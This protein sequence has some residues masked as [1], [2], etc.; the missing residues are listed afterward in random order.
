MTPAPRFWSLQAEAWRQ[1][2]RNLRDVWDGRSRVGFWVT[3]GAAVVVIGALIGAANWW[4]A[5]DAIVITSLE[6]GS[7]VPRCL[8]SFGGKGQLAQ[9]HQ[10]W[11]TVQFRD[12]NGD[13]RALFTRRA[14][15][16]NG[17]WHAEKIDVGGESQALS[18][19]TI[20]AV[21]V[22]RATDSMLR[23]TVVDMSFS[24]AETQGKGRDLWRLSFEDYPSGARPVA[25]VT[26]TRAQGDQGSCNELI[27]K[28]R[29]KR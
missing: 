10:L 1:A 11:V 18:A 9:G 5:R 7:A 28:A 15:M 13:S 12:R 4:V 22:D 24:D 26:V 3:L 20:T 14:L 27:D 16:S 25:D 8:P 6:E 17:K 2:W 23:S 29:Q 19:Y 21:D